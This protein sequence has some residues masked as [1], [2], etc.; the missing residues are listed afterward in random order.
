MEG[1]SSPITMK[2][3]PLSERPYEK[4]EREGAGSLSDA[5]LLAILL[6]SGTRRETAVELAMRLLMQSPEKNLSGLARMNFKRLT[7][8][9]GIGRVKALKLLAAFE[10]MKRLAREDFGERPVLANPASIADYYMQ[11]LRFL[12]VEEVHVL[13]FNTKCIFLGEKRL[14]VGTVN[15]SL[16]SPREIFI[17]ALQREAVN[18]ILVHNHPS[19]DP[20]ASREDIHLTVQVAQAGKILE[21]R[22]LDHIIIGDNRYFSFKEN[23][24]AP[25]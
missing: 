21:V 2:E 5:E 11:S 18:I 25:F 1:N 10:L 13:F 8:V 14:S 12:T 3:L 15:A 17:E 23:G 22:L 4:C 6:Q 9:H 7:A 16:I 24:C 19:G 20:T